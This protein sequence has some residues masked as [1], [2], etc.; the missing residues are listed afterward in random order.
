MTS[1]S[2]LARIVPVAVVLAA[3]LI[4]WYARRAADECRPAELS[5]GGH[6]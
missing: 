4:V 2:A 6:A 1:E 5:G 3:L